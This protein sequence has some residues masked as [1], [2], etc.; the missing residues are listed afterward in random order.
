LTG[1]LCCTSREDLRFGIETHGQGFT[2]DRSHT[3]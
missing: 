1:K 3:S 2:E